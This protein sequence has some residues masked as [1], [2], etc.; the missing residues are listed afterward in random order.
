MSNTV[1]D[2]RIS[3]DFNLEKL[4]QILKTK[5]NDPSVLFALG[6]M[7]F[8]RGRNLIALSAFN[9]LLDLTPEVVEIRLALARILAEQKIFE[10]AYEQIAA[11]LEHDPENAEARVLFAVFSSNM[12][13][14][15]AI[16]Q[17]LEPILSRPFDPKR[18][19]LYLDRLAVERDWLS[20]DLQ[21]ISTLLETSPLDTFLEYHQAVVSRKLSAVSRLF[22]ETEALSAIKYEGPKEKM[23]VV[24]SI[25][26]RKSKAENNL[27]K[28]GRIILEV[29]KAAEPFLEKVKSV[30]GVMSV[31]LLGVKGEVYHSL[32]GSP[33]DWE[34]LAKALSAG[35]SN[36]QSFSSGSLFWVVEFS[37]G[38]LVLQALVPKLFLAIAAEAPLTFGALRYKLD[39]HLPVIQKALES[40]EVSKLDA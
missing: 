36:Y 18:V 37:K 38:V 24:S 2:Y 3:A 31:A 19:R 11:A 32:Q 17:T 12:P 4:E 39:K 8:R 28:R 25:S 27:A 40:L 1:P 21:E 7:A 5:P 16:L 15:S 23:N 22:E 10:E 30:S 26:D 14:T 9:R 13:P 6:E 20:T 35:L 34:G 33:V 29:V